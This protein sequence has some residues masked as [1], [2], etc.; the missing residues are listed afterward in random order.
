[1]KLYPAARDIHL[2]KDILKV[3]VDSLKSGLYYGLQAAKRLPYRRI[4]LFKMCYY[5]YEEDA[6]AR[7]VCA[8][9]SGTTTYL[10]SKEES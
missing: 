9:L 5:R 3:V 2:K 6:I 4:G 10:F 1:M 7:E 8:S